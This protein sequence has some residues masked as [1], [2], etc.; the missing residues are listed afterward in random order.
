[1]DHLIW[2]CGAIDVS[3]I[4]GEGE[5]EGE[6]IT[7]AAVR[8]KVQTD[9][10]GYTLA[11]AGVGVCTAAAGVLFPYLAFTSLVMLYLFT[12]VLV[13][14]SLRRGPAIFCLRQRD[15]LLLFVLNTGPSK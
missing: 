5:G 13:S 8:S 7:P 2:N 1:V 10:R 4:S 15:F 14:A 3:V 9:L 12:V 6:K 11:A